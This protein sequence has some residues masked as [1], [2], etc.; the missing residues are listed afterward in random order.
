MTR[1]FLDSSALFSAAY[2]SGGS[3]R[4]LIRAA[5]RGEFTLVISPEVLDETQRNLAK[6]APQALHAYSTILSLG[7]PE[8]VET[9]R[10]EE[11]W[12]AEEYVHRKDAF[13]IAAAKRAQVD[14]LVTWDREHLLDA[15]KVAERSELTIITPDEMMTIPR[16]QRGHRSGGHRRTRSE[17]GPRNAA[18]R[19]ECPSAATGCGQPQPPGRT[20]SQRRTIRWSTPHPPRG[21]GLAWS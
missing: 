1:A 2:S 15:P 13:I 11:V 10:R 6:K 3:S 14:Y 19:R 5:I 8:I 21:I 18:M 16:E 12:E 4:Q 7:E 20:A 17:S 9:P